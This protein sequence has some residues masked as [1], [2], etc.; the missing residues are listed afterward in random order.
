MKKGLVIRETGGFACKSFR[1]QADSFTLKSK[2][3]TST[4]RL[5][6]CRRIDF[7]CVVESNSCM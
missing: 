3:S 2:E 1:L 7:K 4:N 5:Y 6:L